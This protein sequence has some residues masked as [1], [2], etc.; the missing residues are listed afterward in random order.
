MAKQVSALSSSIRTAICVACLVALYAFTPTSAHA[1]EWRAFCTGDRA[2][3]SSCEG[4]KF[5][6]SISANH[7]T[8]GGWSWS[9]VWNE[10]YGSNAN[11]CQSGNCESWAQVPGTGFGKE[12]M[13]NI[14]GKTYY[15]SPDWWGHL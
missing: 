15:F 2:A 7:S 1:N 11:S 8:N 6:P 10:V 12:Q 5:Y 9:W 4:P 3:N 13:A 14:A